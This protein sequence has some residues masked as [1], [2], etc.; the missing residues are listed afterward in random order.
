MARALAASIL[1][2]PVLLGPDTPTSA[3]A[4]GDCRVANALRTAGQTEA[5]VQAYLDV[6][7]VTPGAVCAFRGIRSL[8][9]APP[10]DSCKIVRTLADQDARAAAREVLTEHLK[11]GKDC[12]GL[13]LA[14]LA[15]EESLPAQ[16]DTWVADWVE[17]PLKVIATVGGVIILLALLVFLLMLRSEFFARRVR[18]RLAAQLVVKPFGPPKDGPDVT[19]AV[20][21]QV[22]ELFF[23]GESL[24]GADSIYIVDAY[25][26]LAPVIDELEKVNASLAPAAAFARALDSLLPRDRW[27]LTGSF[28]VP[29]PGRMACS[30][31]F[32]DNGRHVAATTFE[33]PTAGD[34]PVEADTLALVPC[35]VGWSQ[36]VAARRREQ[37]T[38]GATPTAYGW[39]R[40]GAAAQ[41]RGDHRVAVACYSAAIANDG[42][43]EMARIALALARAVT[44]DPAMAVQILDEMV[45]RLE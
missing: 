1:A 10:A 19:A 35:V 36:L 16:A 42:T 40:G 34:E 15:D 12:P 29:G 43:D 41:E 8:A 4:P 17:K 6:L 14:D 13:S 39:L 38:S 23:L 9:S 37:P 7:K 24:L 28:Y 30:V 33:V 11:K 2:M 27:M 44:A 18:L 25:Q 31:S 45:M 5:A 22:R 3:A 20:E 32:T 26:E 21:S